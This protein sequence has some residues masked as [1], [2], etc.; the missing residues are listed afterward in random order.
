MEPPF[1]PASAALQFRFTMQTRWSDEDNQGVLNNAIYPTLF[2]EARHRFFGE[3]G[4]LSDNR[5]PFLLAQ[6]NVRF[7][8]PGAGGLEIVVEGGTTHVGRSSFVQVYR[9]LPVDGGPAWCE[10]EALLVVVDPTTGR[11]TP[12]EAR[13]RQALEPA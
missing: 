5:F 7:L 12:M 6:S 10:A 3:R 1:V 9:V 11:P 2:E 4:L 8:A 13:F